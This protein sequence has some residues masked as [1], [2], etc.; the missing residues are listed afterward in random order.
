[1]DTKTSYNKLR[2]LEVT[3]FYSEHINKADEQVINERRVH[4][5]NDIRS[6]FEQF[7]DQTGLGL[8]LLDQLQIRERTLVHNTELA[9][10]EED[11]DYLILNHQAIFDSFL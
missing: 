2:R 5:I 4:L 10:V 8:N 6:S 1:M 7:Y 9:Y 3:V 11:N